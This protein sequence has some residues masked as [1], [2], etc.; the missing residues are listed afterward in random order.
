MPHDAVY[1]ADHQ[2]IIENYGVDPDV[3]VDD[4]PGSNGDAQ[5]TVSVQMLLKQLRAQPVSPLKPPPLP[6]Y[7][8]GA[9]PR[10]RVGT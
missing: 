5:L 4:K 10:A 1:G 3:I 8:Q 6:A 9:K 2:W 7:P